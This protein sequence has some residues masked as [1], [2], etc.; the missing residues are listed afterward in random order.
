M[1]VNGELEMTV[2]H[3]DGLMGDGAEVCFDMAQSEYNENCGNPEW[4]ED[5]ERQR[6]Q[7][8]RNHRQRTLM[9]K[10]EIVDFLCRNNT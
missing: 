7:K 5:Q 9:S 1:Q 10:Q 2:I 4:R 6:D 8:E 3:G